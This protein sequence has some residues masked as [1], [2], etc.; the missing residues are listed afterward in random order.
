MPFKFFQ[1][2]IGT[3]CSTAIWLQWVHLDESRFICPKIYFITFLLLHSISAQESVPEDVILPIHLDH[4]IKCYKSLQKS[5]TTIT[6]N[7][8][9]FVD[10]TNFSP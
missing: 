2:L 1:T 6:M 3:K 4:R 9:Q 5:I 10:N 7:F 8:Y